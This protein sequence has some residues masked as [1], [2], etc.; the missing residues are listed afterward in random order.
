M[1]LV[2]NRMQQ[3]Q[4]LAK[5]GGAHRL[6]HPVTYRL[7]GDYVRCGPESRC[8]SE[9]IISEKSQDGTASI[10]APTLSELRATCVVYPIMYEGVNQ[11][12]GFLAVSYTHLTLPT[13]R[14]V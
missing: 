13:K 14:I 8:M 2:K 12:N 7:F 10:T 11:L 4:D 3:L 1:L 9:A 5:S 6:L